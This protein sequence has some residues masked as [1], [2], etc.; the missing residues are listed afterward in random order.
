MEILKFFQIFP[1]SGILYI[2][3]VL[4]DKKATLRDRIILKRQ[5][6]SSEKN[7]S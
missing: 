5:L 2:E 3:Q 6:A 7:S 1:F 4:F